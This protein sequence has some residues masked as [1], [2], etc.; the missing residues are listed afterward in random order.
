LV[1]VFVSKSVKRKREKM[2]SSYNGNNNE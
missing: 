2:K 1:S